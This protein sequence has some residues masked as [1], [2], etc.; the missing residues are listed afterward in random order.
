MYSVYSGWVLRQQVGFVVFNRLLPHFCPCPLSLLSFFS[1]P[2]V[3]IL[4]RCSETIGDFVVGRDNLSEETTSPWLAIKIDLLLARRIIYTRICAVS[5]SPVLQF[6]QPEASVTWKHPDDWYRVPPREKEK[7]I[8][9]NRVFSHDTTPS[10]I[11]NYLICSFTIINNK[12]VTQ[13]ED[14]TWHIL[15]RMLLKCEK[16]GTRERYPTDHRVGY[17]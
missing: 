2:M 1:T 14:H 16:A 4:R 15:S 11:P 13:S 9:W 17:F 10:R 5:V 12:S 6:V 8:Q 3:M 7:R